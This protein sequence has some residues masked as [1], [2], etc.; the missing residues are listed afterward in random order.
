MRPYCVIESLDALPDGVELAVFN[1]GDSGDDV[2]ALDGEDYVGHASG[3]VCAEELY[4]GAVYHYVE[5]HFASFAVEGCR[6]ARYGEEVV[7]FNFAC[8]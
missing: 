2:V 7:E 6:N 1:T 8:G 3:A 4:R 5:L